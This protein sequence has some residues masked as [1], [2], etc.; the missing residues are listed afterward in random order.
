MTATRYLTGLVA[1]ASLALLALWF[2]LPRAG[3]AVSLDVAHGARDIRGFLGQSVFVPCE[4]RNDTPR[5]VT[6]E[7][8]RA[9]CSCAE[10]DARLKFPMTLNAGE[11]K[12]FQLR[13]GLDAPRDFVLGLEVVAKSAD[14][15]VISGG[16]NVDVICIRRAHAVPAVIAFGKAT[17]AEP[18]E[19]STLLYVPRYLASPKNVE[20]SVSHEALKA[21][22]VSAAEMPDD[23]SFRREGFD[24]FGAVSVRAVPSELPR[25]LSGSVTLT[26]DGGDEV[27][28][29]VTGWFEP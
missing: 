4:L 21:K 24:V 2:F 10:L 22:F 8:I 26:L 14:G 5:A 6:V 16:D 18:V 3:A 7:N 11:T 17:S 19:A 20:L 12:A 28:V 29:P 27:L 13:V 15:T 25:E 23:A 1:S 9:S